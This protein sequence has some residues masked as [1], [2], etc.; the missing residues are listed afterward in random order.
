MESIWSFQFCILTCFW[1]RL[2]REG[3]PPY[4]RAVNKAPLQWERIWRKNHCALSCPDYEERGEKNVDCVHV[5]EDCDIYRVLF[6]TVPLHFQ[7][8]KKNLH[9]QRG[10]FSTF[11]IMN[12]KLPWLM[13]LQRTWICGTGMICED[14]MKLWRSFYTMIIINLIW[15]WYY[16]MM[17]IFAIRKSVFCSSNGEWV[18]P[19][20]QG[21]VRL[22]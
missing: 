1:M 17:I 5:H 8:Q 9:S 6:L 13:R 11:S 7:Y 3:G 15:Q 16:N 22:C 14:D 4:W 19:K 12:W 18:N 10:S 21:S 20:P 2:V